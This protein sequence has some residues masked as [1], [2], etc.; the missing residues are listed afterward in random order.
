MPY[1]SA[2]LAVSPTDD[3]F[4]FDLDGTLIDL[5]DAPDEARVPPEVPLLLRRLDL[6]TAGA[7]AVVSG[8]SLADIARLLPD[9]DLP[10]AGEH[11][12]EIRVPGKGLLPDGSASPD[13]LRKLAAAAADVATWAGTRPGVLVERK[14]RSVALHYRRRPDVADE[15]LA[16]AGRIAR[17]LAPTIVLQAGKMVAELRV[18]GADKGD[19]V[20][21]IMRLPAFR[22]RR[23][24]VFGD[25]LT[26]A[27]A[28]EA[29][30]ELGGGGVFI[31]AAGRPSGASAAFAAP[32]DLRRFLLHVLSRPA[33]CP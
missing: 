6:R 28:F 23:P 3:A 27:A 4:F 33:P 15:A 12:A 31:G 18:A 20:R 1:A 13:G 29:A 21:R 24:L 11:G 9:L 16:M 25:D 32:V 19:A 30:A 7:T 26:D 14:E 8:R 22:G 5:A 10:V 2:S 17:A